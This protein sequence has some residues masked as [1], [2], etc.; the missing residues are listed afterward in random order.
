V[1]L[2]PRSGAVPAVGALPPE[3]MCDLLRVPMSGAARC[4]LFLAC[5]LLLRA[6]GAAA[7]AR[8]DGILDAYPCQW[9]STAELETGTALINLH[10]ELA[11]LDVARTFPWH[12]VLPSAMCSACT[13]GR[14]AVPP[15][16]CWPG[17]ECCG[18]MAYSTVSNETLA[19]ALGCKQAPPGRVHAVGLRES[20]LNGRFDAP[21]AIAAM[22]TLVSH[23]LVSL[24]LSSNFLEGSIP[25]TLNLN[26]N[27]ARIAN[28][29]RASCLPACLPACRPAGLPACLPVKNTPCM[30]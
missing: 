21:A 25:P 27:R 29:L 8:S 2:A 3:I 1:Q 4:A 5:L 11:G 14:I 17:V 30:P 10:T 28:A 24:D 15:F 7:A 20:F 12:D 22:A 23:G 9:Q 19:D 6:A 16:C 13:S 26:A 18:E